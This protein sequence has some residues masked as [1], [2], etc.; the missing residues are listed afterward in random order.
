MIE[1][2]K[3][4]RHEEVSRQLAVHFLVLRG[5]GDRLIQAEVELVGS[6]DAAT[7]APRG[8]GSVG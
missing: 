4:H 2:R 6:V 1:R 8:A 7:A 5:S 3:P